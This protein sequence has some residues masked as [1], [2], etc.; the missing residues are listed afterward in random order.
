MRKLGS[1]LAAVFVLVACGGGSTAA[2][3]V[4]HSPS[5]LPGAL[6]S[7]LIAY[8][9]DRGVGV[10]DP[11]NGKTALVSPLPAGGAF[12]AS[13]PV[14]GPAPDLPYPVIYFTIHDDRPAESR[15]SPGVVPYDW[16]FAVDPF[17]G[18][19]AP[20]AASLD[21]QSE[22]PIGLVANDHYLGLTFGCCASY[23][24]DALDLGQPARGLKVL[25]RPPAQPPFFTEGAAPG[26]SPLIAVRQFGTGTWYWLNA[27]AAVLQPF[28]LSLGPDDGPIAIS[29]DGTR[30]AVALPD[31]GAVVEPIN[32]AVPLASPTPPAGV[33]PSGA[34]SPSP[35]ASSRPSATPP[36]APHRVNSKLPH[37]DGLAWAPDGQQ[38]AVAV[39]GEVELY[40]ASAADGTAPAGVYLRGG[41]V[42]GVSWSAAMPD[43]TFSMV[44]AAPSPQAMVDA[45]LDATKLP[46]A[47]DTPANRPFTKVYAW[48]FDSSKTSPISSIADATAA[49][50]ARYPPLDAGVV[51]HHWAPSQP[52]AFAGGCI[53]Y[54]VVIT[55]SIP[56]VATTVGLATSA[57]CSAPKASA[58]P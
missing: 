37:P 32:V 51:I 25:A 33:S 3:A 31:H 49:I 19:I 7:G 6:T 48:S 11:A 43:R 15:D 38:L 24:V 8:I 40:A 52:W 30:A 20:V 10:L 42:L 36:A 4:T 14:W 22:G 21:Q 35:A 29:A 54:R 16:L 5:A 45:L 26:A 55:G 57:L 28:P 13:G 27:D 39:S 18:T 23:E 56:A 17:Q 34:A 41:N 58:S 50:L 44:K 46:V 2:P 53:R 12:R 9:T 47:A 1:A